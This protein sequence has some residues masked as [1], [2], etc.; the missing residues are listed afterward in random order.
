MRTCFIGVDRRGRGLRPKGETH[1]IPVRINVAT[2]NR[3][4]FWKLSCEESHETALCLDG[5]TKCPIRARPF[6]T[7]PQVVQAEAQRQG[8]ESTKIII[9][10]FHGRSAC[11]KTA[12]SGDSIVDLAGWSLM[13]FCARAMRG[14][15][16]PSLDARRGR[17][18]SPLLMEKTENW[19]LSRRGKTPDPSALRISPPLKMAAYVSRAIDVSDQ[20]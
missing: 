8:Y 11:L 10:V 18:S 9:D 4:R 19:S 15:G 5:G 14:R 20:L 17:P 16:L 12:C 3:I 7:L 13:I 2:M 6:T 1:E